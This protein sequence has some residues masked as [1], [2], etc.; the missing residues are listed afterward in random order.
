MSEWHF[1]E[2]SL[3]AAC[4]MGGGDTETLDSRRTT[5]RCYITSERGDLGPEKGSCAGDRKMEKKVRVLRKVQE[6]GTYREDEV[7]HKR[8]QT[9]KPFHSYFLYPSVLPSFIEIRVYP[10]LIT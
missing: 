6:E 7:C 1:G 3:P 9:V 10:F 8:R 2:M 4:G 5:R